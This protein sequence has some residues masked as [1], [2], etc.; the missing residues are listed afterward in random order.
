MLFF[1]YIVRAIKTVWYNQTFE[2]IWIHY[3]KHNIQIRIQKY[4]VTEL[5]IKCKRKHDIDNNNYLNNLQ[6]YQNTKIMI[7]I[8][9]HIKLKLKENKYK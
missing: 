1:S 6:V 7:F 5:S 8:K 4:I 9:M 3:L 2:Y